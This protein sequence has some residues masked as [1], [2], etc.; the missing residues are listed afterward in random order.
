[1]FVAILWL[2]LAACIWG[3]ISIARNH[4][5]AIIS[6][7]P[8]ESSLTKEA[9][10]KADLL[11]K[12]FSRKL[13]LI[14]KETVTWFGPI[15]TASLGIFRRAKDKAITWE[16][17]YRQQ[18]LKDSLSDRVKIQ[19]QVDKLLAKAEGLAKAGKLLEA[20][21]AYL[22]VLNWDDKN[23]LAYTGLGEVYWRQKDYVHAKDTFEFLLKLDNSNPFVHRSL[24]GV[25]RD[26]G[27]LKTAQEHFGSLVELEKTSPIAYLDLASI[28]L[29]LE[30]PHRAFALAQ[31]AAVLEPNN[32]KVL[33][34]LLEVSIIMQDKEA[35]EKTLKQLQEVNPDNQ[36]LEEF[37]TRVADL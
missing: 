27:D 17:N 6:S 29:A 28:Y 8:Q 30:N 36:K 31:E 14:K 2:V 21:K 15:F 35:A 9:I 3:L 13:E 24:G 4:W 10:T 32:P 7:R 34:F 16:E 23:V 22:E 12:R 26:A 25:A 19:Q 11:E 18:I 37:K 20:E 1:M 5:T 33:D